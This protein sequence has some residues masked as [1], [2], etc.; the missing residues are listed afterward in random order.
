M[1]MMKILTQCALLL[2][3]V[4]SAY[5]DAAA[6]VKGTRVTL[7]PP[8][9]FT[10][11][12]RFPGYMSE[13]TGASL[14]VTELPAPFAVA[15]QGFNAAGFKTKGMTLLTE[16]KLKFGELQGGLYSASQAAQGVEF[17]KWMAIFGD[18][19]T[20]YI[21][22]AAFPKAHAEELSEKLKAAVRSAKAGGAAADPMDAV[23]FRVKPAGT[24]KLAKVIANMLLFTDNG[25]FPA[26]GVEN[27]LFVAAAS[28]T[29]AMPIPDQRLFA[30]A[31]LRQVQALKEIKP[32]ETIPFEAS[33][34]KGFE[35]TADA[36]DAGTGEKAVLY[37]AILYDGNG[38]YL[39]QG[40]ASDASRDA[41]VPVF[42]EMARSFTTVSAAK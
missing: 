33:G 4:F 7:E 41:M 19:S 5:A 11:A 25:I 42:K 16:E 12:D 1:T 18:A 23:T 38:Y 28:I 30:E 40:I 6:P 39:M 24:M 8:V 26:R 22:T 20:T 21:V 3:C 34:L 2:S 13:E 35:S 15:S 17:L 10:V 36:L 37:Q 31:R 27:P 29:Q 32:K 9:G 14:M